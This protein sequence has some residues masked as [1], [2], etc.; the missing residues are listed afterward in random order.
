MMRAT[1]STRLYARA[2]RPNL[3]MEVSGT[4]ALLP[5]RASSY[6]LI[7]SSLV[8]LLQSGTQ[9]VISFFISRCNWRKKSALATE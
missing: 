8:V 3:L 2:L 7:F 4:Q 6:Q 5:V 9:I 1:L